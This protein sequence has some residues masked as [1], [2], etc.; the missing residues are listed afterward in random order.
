MKHISDDKRS[1]AHT[2]KCRSGRHDWIE[3]NIGF[4]G[5]FGRGQQRYCKPC[6]REAS[7]ASRQRQKDER[8]EAKAAMY[9]T[10]ERPL[11]DRKI[12][13]LRVMVRCLHCGAVPTEQLDGS[14]FTPHRD[15]CYGIYGRDAGDVAKPRAAHSTAQAPEPKAERTTCLSGRHSWPEHMVWEGVK[16]RKR[17]CKACRQ[18]AARRRTRERAEA[19]GREYVPKSPDRRFAYRL[20]T[21]EQIDSG[22]P[23]STC[24]SG[25][26]PWVVGNVRIRERVKPG[27]R[28]QTLYVRSC[29]RCA[30]ATSQRGHEAAAA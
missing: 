1:P 26:H 18:E 8:Q 3:E 24:E 13:E 4:R 20:A 30:E 29:A 28:G 5:R 25:Q 22:R 23:R 10:Q 27:A 16:T 21:Q 11:T 17:A 6:Y 14:V 12:L 7:K 2:G 15:G 9:V 19:A